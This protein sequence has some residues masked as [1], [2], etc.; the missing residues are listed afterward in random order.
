MKD[1]VSVT[2]WLERS[3]SLK[4]S[5][6]GVTASLLTAALRPTSPTASSARTLDENKTSKAKMNDATVHA[7]NINCNLRPTSRVL[8]LPMRSKRARKKEK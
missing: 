5:R 8:P 7:E 4:A 3:I 6:V 1:F 2:V